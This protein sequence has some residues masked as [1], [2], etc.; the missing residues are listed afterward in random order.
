MRILYLFLIQRVYCGVARYA[1][2][3]ATMQCL[4]LTTLGLLFSSNVLV[5]RM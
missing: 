2:S 4:E 1:I 5:S 3:G